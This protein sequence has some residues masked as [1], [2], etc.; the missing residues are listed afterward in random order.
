EE[1][2]KSYSEQ[3]YA[4]FDQKFLFLKELLGK[5]TKEDLKHINRLKEKH[6]LYKRTDIQLLIDVG[7]AIKSKS[8]EWPEMTIKP[9][10][11]CYYTVIYYVNS[12]HV[13][14]ADPLSPEDKIIFANNLN[15]TKPFRVFSG[16]KVKVLCFTYFSDYQKL[17]ALGKD[18]VKV[19]KE[20]PITELD[21]LISSMNPK[22]ISH[23]DVLLKTSTPK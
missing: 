19:T 12:S 3:L 7:P 10:L 11:N 18:S 4:K 16:M 21:K 5:A 14:I 13:R 6:L 1:L 15:K 23:K 9:N 8:R 20:F 17:F 22:H 2:E